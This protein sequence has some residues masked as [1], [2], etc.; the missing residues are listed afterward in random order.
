VDDWLERY[1]RDLG[2]PFGQET[3]DNPML[4]SGETTVEF[5]D[6]GGDRTKVIVTSR[7]VCA[8]ELIAMAQAGWNSQLDKL[9]VLLAS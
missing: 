3:T 1:P 2:G 4:E 9:E 8:Q 6:L 5:I 7:M